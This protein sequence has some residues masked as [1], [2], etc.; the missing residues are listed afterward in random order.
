MP[1]S[2]LFS[3]LQGAWAERSSKVEATWAEL[4]ST[5]PKWVAYCFLDGYGWH[6]HRH[7]TSCLLCNLNTLWN[8]LMILGRNVD[9]DEMTC[10][11]QD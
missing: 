10:H 9:E 4:C 11:I 6:Q 8:I 7:K 1:P 5:L 2:G 3:T